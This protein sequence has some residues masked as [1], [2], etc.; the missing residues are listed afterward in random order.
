M[1]QNKDGRI[2]WDYAQNNDDIVGTD[3]YTALGKATCGWGYWF[4]N[5]VGLCG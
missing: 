1:V 5:L 2:P 4:K 3:K